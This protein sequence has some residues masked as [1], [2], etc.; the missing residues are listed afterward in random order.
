ML[1]GKFFLGKV[2]KPKPKIPYLYFIRKSNIFQRVTPR[3]KKNIKKKVVKMK[4]KLK[5]FEELIRPIISEDDIKF[6]H[7]LAELVGKIGQEKE[8]TEEDELPDYPDISDEEVDI[9]VE[10]LLR[11]QK[12]SEVLHRKS[13]NN[14]SFQL[15]KKALEGCQ[16]KELIQL[17]NEEIGSFLDDFIF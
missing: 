13:L 17:Y 2:I 15:N 11:G 12:D 7:H 16:A 3:I 6:Y 4:G 5:S 14:I 1:E 8:I 9:R 10:I